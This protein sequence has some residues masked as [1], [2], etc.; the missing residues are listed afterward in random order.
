MVSR[1]RKDAKRA[2]VCGPP[3]DLKLRLRRIRLVM[4]ET[5]RYRDGPRDVQ[6]TSGA[7]QIS[8][9]AIVG[10]PGIRSS[11]CCRNN[12][13]AW[14]LPPGVVELSQLGLT[15]TT[16]GE[17]GTGASQDLV[18]PCRPGTRVEALDIGR[19]DFAAANGHCDCYTGLTQRL[20]APDLR[21]TVTYL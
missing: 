16:D 5:N 4:N 19:P 6:S 2:C 20:L 14:R 18:G 17:R 21:V 13:Y 9:R 12:R 8:T 11:G 10:H 1:C 7:P 15:L 3:G